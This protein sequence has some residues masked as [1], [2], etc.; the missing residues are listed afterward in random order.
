MNRK[1]MIQILED[2]LPK[3]LGPL[4][5]DLEELKER[6]KKIE[7]DV[8]WIRHDLEKTDKGA[9]PKSYSSAA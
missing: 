7:T 4:K 8:E 9:T 2:V 6:T 3:F 5:K 1:E